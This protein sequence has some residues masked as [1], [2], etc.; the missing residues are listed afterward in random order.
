VLSHIDINYT[1]FNPNGN[2]LRA[3]VSATFVKYESEQAVAAAAR[4]SST[5]LTHFRTTREG[6]RLDLMT[7]NIY[8]DP[9]LF[10]QVARVNNLISVRNIKPGREL[11]FP[12]INKN[13]S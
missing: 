1:L 3:R 7:N 12:P 4:M 9:G 10:L 5:D 11:Y 13:E 8:S 2:P 6:D